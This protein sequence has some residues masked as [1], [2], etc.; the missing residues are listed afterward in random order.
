ME[1]RRGLWRKNGQAYKTMEK[2]RANIED[3]TETTGK[4]RGVWRNNGQKWRAKEK[5][6]TNVQGLWRNNGQT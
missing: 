1:K 5:Q 6:W 4:H 2:Q 3:Y